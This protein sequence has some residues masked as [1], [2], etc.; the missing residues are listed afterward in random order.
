[1]ALLHFN[2]ATLIHPQEELVAFVQRVIAHTATLP[3]IE[4]RTEPRRPVVLPAPAQAIDEH[5]RPRGE[6]FVA[7]TRDLSTRGIAIYHVR[8][9]AAGSLLALE[10]EVA[11]G[12]TMQVVLEVLRCRP[13]GEFYEIAGTFL[14]KVRDAP[15][16]A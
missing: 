6:P 16:P 12:D 2:P 7:I 8:P 15:P 13:A 4:R 10:L 5:L 9:V 3:G 11:P 14:T 1:M